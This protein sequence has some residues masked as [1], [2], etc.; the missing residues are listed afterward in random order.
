MRKEDILKNMKDYEIERSINKMCS[1][2]KSGVLLEQ[3]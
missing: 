2:G 1:S 3:S